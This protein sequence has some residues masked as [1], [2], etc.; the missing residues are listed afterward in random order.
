MMLLS[1]ADCKLHITNWVLG[2]EVGRCFVIKCA[3][4]RASNGAAHSKFA[5][6]NVKAASCPEPYTHLVRYKHAGPICFA[7]TGLL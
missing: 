5:I 2:Q 6:C 1:I 4:G 7:L 3:L